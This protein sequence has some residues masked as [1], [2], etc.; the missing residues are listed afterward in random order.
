MQ[1]KSRVVILTASNQLWGTGLRDIYAININ[2]TTTFEIDTIN[3][4]LQRLQTIRHLPNNTE[5][6]KD[7]DPDGGPKS[8]CQASPEAG[9]LLTKRSGGK[10]GKKWRDAVRLQKRLENQ[11]ESTEHYHAPGNFSASAIPAA[12]LLLILPPFKT[13]A[14]PVAAKIRSLASQTSNTWMGYRSLVKPIPA[15]FYCSRRVNAAS[16]I[17]QKPPR[18]LI[19]D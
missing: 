7:L 9:L 4:L 8:N 2:L 15:Y 12:D 16:S 10:A 1:Q 3:P 14:F 13:S 17:E 18:R 11:I 19:L 5:K 6:N